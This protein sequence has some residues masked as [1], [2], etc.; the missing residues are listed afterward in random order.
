MVT[1]WND[2]KNYRLILLL[3]E[4][5][6]ECWFLYA[7]CPHKK[8]IDCTW[9]RWILEKCCIFSWQKSYSSMMHEPYR[10]KYM[11]CSSRLYFGN[12]N[13]LHCRFHH[14]K[15]IIFNIIVC[16]APRKKKQLKFLC[17]CCFFVLIRAL[18]KG[19]QQPFNINH[20]QNARKIFRTISVFLLS[21][22]NVQRIGNT[23]FHWTK[24]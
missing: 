6:A 11:L 19:C 22:A 3:W 24:N 8:H 20:S 2:S 13:K 16:I 10:R 21:K 14:I 18:K 23:Y 5:T 7:L 9:P 12:I 1:F 17:C 15:W 4:N